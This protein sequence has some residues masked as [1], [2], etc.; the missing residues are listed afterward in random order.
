MK[1]KLSLLA[2]CVGTSMLTGCFDSDNSGIFNKV[3]PQPTLAS[4]YK[5]VLDRT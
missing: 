4:Q 5:N 2:L 3:N 1:T